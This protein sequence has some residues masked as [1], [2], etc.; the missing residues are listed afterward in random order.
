MKVYKRATVIFV[1]RGG[2]GV[3][4]VAWC[5]LWM[6]AFSRPAAA[7]YFFVIRK[8]DEAWTSPRFLPLFTCHHVTAREQHRKWPIA[9]V[10]YRTFIYNRFRYSRNLL[11]IV[12]S[13]FGRAKP[14]PVAF[15]WLQCYTSGLIT[16]N[17]LVL[18]RIGTKNIFLIIVVHFT[19][20]TKEAK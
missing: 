2:G 8:K 11:L 12:L 14:S 15:K 3:K 4:N 5:R 19:M 17:I 1:E 20:C 7:K 10:S 9:E 6:Y 18:Y 16:W 13:I